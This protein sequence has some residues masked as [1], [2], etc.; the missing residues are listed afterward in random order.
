[1]RAPRKYRARILRHGARLDV[2]EDAPPP[3]TSPCLFS[4]ILSVPLLGTHRL[5]PPVRVGGLAS[6]SASSPF[7][8]FFLN[9]LLKSAPGSFAIRQSKLKE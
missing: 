2:P 3:F 6:S 1:M 5:P 8:F 9:L 7:P 4:L